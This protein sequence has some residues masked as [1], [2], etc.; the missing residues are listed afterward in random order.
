MRRL[1]IF[2]AAA[3]FSFTSWASAQPAPAALPANAP[4]AELEKAN[5]E[6][7]QWRHTRLTAETG[8]LTL[9]GLHWLQPGDNALGSA[10]GSKLPLPA[11]KA[12]AKVAVLRLEGGKVTLVPEPGSGLKVG[13]HEVTAPLPLATDADEE[14]T[15][16]E[17]GTINFYVIARGDRLGLRI[18]DREAKLRR[19]FPGLDY[20]PF[21]PS[22]RVEAKFAPNPPGTTVPVAD[23]L[24]MTQQMPSPG[25]VTLTMKGQ[26]FTLT[27]LDDTGDG[28]LYL[29]VGDATNGYDTYG[30]GRFLYA[31]VPKDGVTVVD[32]NRAYN[33]PC[34]FTP[35]S[36]CQLPPKENKLP[37]RI[38]AGEKKF[39]AEP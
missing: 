14:P 4:L 18:R 28:R 29:I 31:D 16:V 8:W 3:A 15:L 2:A 36:T 30:A 22:F 12:P 34:A 1:P 20:F 25:K 5:L 17:L 23:V 21:D 39:H 37:L 27:A 10:P 6:W 11:D 19:E 38:E 26:T 9:I 33:P 32:F 24:G 35:W 7:R 13:D